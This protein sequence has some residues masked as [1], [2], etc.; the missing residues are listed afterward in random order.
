[1]GEP[2]KKICQEKN[3]EVYLPMS[4]T[5]AAVAEREIQSLKHIIY[6][7][8]ENHGKIFVPNLQHY[9]SI[10]NCRKNQ[11]IGKPFIK[12]TQPKFK[13]GD[14]VR[15]SKKIIFCS[16]KDTSYSLQMKLLSF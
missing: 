2:L 3:I 15:I 14:R 12:Y 5:K 7:Y 11:S 9:V 8:I 1:M 10:L 4:E 6:R 13:I 16:E